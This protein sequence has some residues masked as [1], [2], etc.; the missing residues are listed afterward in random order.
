MKEVGRDINSSSSKLSRDMPLSTFLQRVFVPIEEPPITHCHLVLAST[1][2]VSHDFCTTKPKGH[3]A[4]LNYWVSVLCLT[5][6][7][8]L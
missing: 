6:S 5:L 7:Y 1:T 4:S 2:E 3:Y 8:P